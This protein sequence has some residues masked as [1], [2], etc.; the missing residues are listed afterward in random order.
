VSSIFFRMTRP[1][2]LASNKGLA[3][4]LKFSWHPIRRFTNFFNSFQFSS[5]SSS[6]TIARWARTRKLVTNHAAI[7]SNSRG[8]D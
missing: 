2:G 8:N 3:F 4:L 5:A 6:S 1:A 7:S